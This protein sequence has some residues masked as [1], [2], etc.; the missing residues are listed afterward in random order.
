MKRKSHVQRLA[1]I[2]PKN[3]KTEIMY[4]GEKVLRRYLKERIR[5]VQVYMKENKVGQ[6]WLL[7]FYKIK[8]DTR[9]IY[10]QYGV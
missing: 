1:Y 4:S 7:F 2:R 5:D 10:K 8:C 3:D 6:A 9:Q